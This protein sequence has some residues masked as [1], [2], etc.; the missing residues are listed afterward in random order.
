LELSLLSDH[1]SI[2]VTVI[3]PVKEY[4]Q[5]MEITMQSILEQVGVDFQVILI[6]HPNFKQDFSKLEGFCQS[7]RVKFF[8]QDQPGLYQAM[9]QGWLLAEESLICFMGVGDFFLSSQVFRHVVN[10]FRFNSPC[11]LI[12][13]YGPWLFLDPELRLIFPAMNQ[14]FKS[15]ELLKTTTPICHQTVFMSKALIAKLNGFDTSLAV[16]SDR[17]ILDRAA[18]ITV[19]KIWSDPF[20]AYIDGGFSSTNQ[21]NGHKELEYL[22]KLR[23]NSK[24]K[25]TSFFRK[26]FH[27]FKTK[28]RIEGMRM[29]YFSW[30]PEN[31]REYLND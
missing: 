5:S 31:I 19:P 28:P 9:N 8:F 17:D 22:R 12:W 10:M 26:K 2:Q 11:D 14:S 23:Q 6:L 27:Q 3:V 29:D 4:S 18:Q 25:K 20:I 7:Q 1:S 16:A 15:S 30:L 21:A 24:Y 13:G